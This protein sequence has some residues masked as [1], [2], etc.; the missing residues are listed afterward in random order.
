M[1]IQNYLYMLS[2]LKN[3]NNMQF[4][5]SQRERL[6]ALVEGI[7]LLEAPWRKYMA[8]VLKLDNSYK[9]YA[10]APETKELEKLKVKRD[11]DVSWMEHLVKDLYRFG[12]DKETK[13][14]AERISYILKN[15]KGIQRAGYEAATALINNLIEDLEKAE[16]AADVSRLGLAII[17]TDLKQQNDSFQALY[18]TRFDAR[19]AHSQEGNTKECRGFAD[20]A[21]NELCVVITALHIALTDPDEREQTEKII[22]TINAEIEQFYINYHRHSTAIVKR[23]EKEAKEKEEKAKAKAA[24]EKEAKEKESSEKKADKNAPSPPSQPAPIPPAV[25]NPPQTP[26]AAPSPTVKADKAN[27]PPE[28]GRK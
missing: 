24:K 5:L 2:R 16:Y 9:W 11:G 7:P 26:A 25:N 6:A 13:D 28:G 15:Y 10:T 20:T 22:D 8:A 27:P 18:E 14:S 1:I 17:I 12:I 19:Y 23:R 21:F 4:H 3:A